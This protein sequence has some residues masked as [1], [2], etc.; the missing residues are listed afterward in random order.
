MPYLFNSLAFL[1]IL[2]ISLNFSSSF[3]IENK[4]FILPQKKLSEVSS[5]N[6][7]P[8]ITLSK[9]DS[10]SSDLPKKSLLKN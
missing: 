5:T 1:I 2:T 7:K 8:E 3:S 9:N 4:E 10:L 6:K